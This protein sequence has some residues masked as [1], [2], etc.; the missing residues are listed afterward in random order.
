MTALISC[1]K[2]GRSFDIGGQPYVALRDVDLDITQGELVAVTGPSGSGKS[3]LLNLIGGLDQ[4]TA[5]TLEIDSRPIREMREPDLAHLRNILIGFVFQQFNLLPRY[6]AQRNVEM[7][8]IYASTDRP[9]RHARA[10]ELLRFLGLE[11]QANKKPTQM[12]GGQQ[13]RVAIA[14]ALA[15]QPRLILADEP[16]GAL[17]SKTSAEV[18]KLLKDLNQQHNTTVVIVTHDPNVAAQ[19]K[20]QIRFSDGAVLED[21]GAKA[22]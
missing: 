18:V 9:Q 3:T 15:N 6:T 16:T 10:L 7:P 21:T 4:A 17:D 20:R 22:A 1:R 12:S 13:Q 11:Q 5:G 19:C 14:R 2:L 8:M